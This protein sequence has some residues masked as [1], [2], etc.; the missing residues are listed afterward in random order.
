MIKTAFDAIVDPTSG[1]ACM[2]M[3]AFALTILGYKWY[4]MFDQDGLRELSVLRMA[5]CA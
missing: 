5:R 4:G 3:M 2:I 1:T